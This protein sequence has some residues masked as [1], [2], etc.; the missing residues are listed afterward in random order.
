[1]TWFCDLLVAYVSQESISLLYAQKNGWLQET[2]KTTDK[3]L[4]PLKNNTID[5]ML[6]HNHCCDWLHS[7]ETAGAVCCSEKKQHIC[8]LLSLH[9][10][11]HMHGLCRVC[12]YHNLAKLKLY[13]LSLALMFNLQISFACSDFMWSCLTK[14]VSF[15][16]LISF[17]VQLR[18]I[19]RGILQ[20]WHWHSLG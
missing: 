6:V 4:M 7:S 13:K 17:S 16:C 1:M 2:V 19:C 11:K 10:N 15:L 3:F 14:K 18:K 5:R 8:N 12:V 9:H 20:H